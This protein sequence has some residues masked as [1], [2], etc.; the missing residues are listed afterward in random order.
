MK[1]KVI[2][3]R[4]NIFGRILASKNRGIVF[5]ELKKEGEVLAV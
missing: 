3:L 1:F 2:Y 4:V 5:Q